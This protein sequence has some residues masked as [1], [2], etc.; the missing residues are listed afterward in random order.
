MVRRRFLNAL[1]TLLAVAGRP[2]LGQCQPDWLP[3]HAIPGANGPVAAA[4]MWDPD[5]PGPQQPRLVVGGSFT[6]L[7]ASAARNVG[8]WDGVSWSALGAWPRQTVTS[9]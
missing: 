5:G 1:I 6:S 7:G 2:A 8:A 9:L 3:G 4:V